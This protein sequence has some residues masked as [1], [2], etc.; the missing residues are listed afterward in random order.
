MGSSKNCVCVHSARN[1]WRIPESDFLTAFSQNNQ[2]LGRVQPLKYSSLGEGKKGRWSK[3]NWLSILPPAS[4][5]K[6]HLF[7]LKTI[8][9]FLSFSNQRLKHIPPGF[10]CSVSVC[11]FDLVHTLTSPPAQAWPLP[12]YPHSHGCERHTNREFKKIIIKPYSCLVF[13]RPNSVNITVIIQ[14]NNFYSYVLY[15]VQ[16]LFQTL[17]IPYTYFAVFWNCFLYFHLHCHDYSSLFHILIVV[18]VF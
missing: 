16:T 1:A 9:L 17:N 13:Y 3:E 15:T 11:C 10:G 4:G 6:G 14:Y 7:N 12:F 8:T 5:S 2:A 18:W